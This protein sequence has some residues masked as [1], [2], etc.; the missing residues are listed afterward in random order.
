MLINSGQ[1]I[2]ELKTFVACGNSFQAKPGANDDLVMATMLIVRM[3]DTVLHWSSQ[4]GDLKEHIDEDELY[5]EIEAMPVV[6]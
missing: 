2:K 1:L 6:I 5:D 4:T 3:L